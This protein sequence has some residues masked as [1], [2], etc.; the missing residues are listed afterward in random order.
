MIV[1]KLMKSLTILK[2]VS[3][4]LINCKIWIDNLELTYL[5]LLY[6]PVWHWLPV[7]PLG[8]VHLPGEVHTP[9]FK[10]GEGQIAKR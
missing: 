4:S 5:F 1:K 7:Y 3:I 8:H 6:I 9:L 2:S 10:H